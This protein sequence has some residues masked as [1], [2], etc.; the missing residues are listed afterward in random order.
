MVRYATLAARIKLV[1]G[2]GA[3]FDTAFAG[4]FD[5]ATRTNT[6]VEQTGILFTRLAE[7]GKLIGVSSAEALRLTETINQAVQLSGA[8]ADSSGAAIQQLIQGLQ[9]GVLRGDEFN[10]VME[11]SPRLAK[12]LADGLGVTTGELRKMA[13]AGALTSQTVIASLQGQSAALQAEF[14]SLPQTVGRALQSLSNSW[15][16]Y[17]GEVDKATSSARELAEAFRK[18]ADAAIAA[19]NGIAPTWVLA[20]AGA[21]GYE[22]QVD[23]AGK[24]TVKAANDGKQAV[25]ALGDQFRLTTEQVKAQEDA[26][27]RLAMKYKLTADYTERQIA[28]LEREA[29]AHQKVIDTENKRR[30]VDADGFSADKDGKRIVAGTEIGTL[31]GIAAFLKNAGVSDDAAARKLALEFSDGKGDIPY[32]SNPGQKK[33]GGD[34]LSM[35]LLKAAETYT[36]GNNGQGAKTPSSI[37]APGATQTVNINIGGRK[38]AVNVASSSDANALTSVLRQLES[39]SGV[40]A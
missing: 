25:G 7:A 9:S 21:R 31:T 35:A 28:L 26:M 2:E 8:S 36:F 10:S 16:Q 38:T 27:D 19:N 34:T 22:I 11:Q 15:I 20:Q 32:M 13:E 23:S 4:V 24:S 6:A 39:A 18:S 5:V 1:T 37:P 30:G 29:A 12:A 14:E 40:S 33:Y 3:A 17:V